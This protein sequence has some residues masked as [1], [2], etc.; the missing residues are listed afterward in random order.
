MLPL[1][2]ERVRPK[3]NAHIPLIST[4]AGIQGELF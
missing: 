3:S 2:V 4:K 1:I